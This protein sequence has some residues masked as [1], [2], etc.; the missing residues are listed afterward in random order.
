[1]AAGVQASGTCA[2]AGQQARGRVE[3]DPAR[4]GQKHLAPGVQVGEVLFGAA[5]A[6]ERL[7]RQALSWIR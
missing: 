1:M 5:G 2:F 3:P 4:A 7:S 6:V